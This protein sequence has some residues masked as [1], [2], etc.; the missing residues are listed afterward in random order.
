MTKSSPQ[1][2][3]E[4]IMKTR[5]ALI[6]AAVSVLSSC[7]TTA[8]Y[9][10]SGN[11]QRFQDGIYES[12]PGFMTRAEKTELQ[13]GTDVLIAKTKASEIYLF[14]DI[15]DTI[16]IPQNM[17]AT[18]RYDKENGSTAVTVADNPYDW[19]NNID[20]WSVYGSMDFSWRYSYGPWG[21]P[22][23]WERYYDPWY[24]TGWY[25]GYWGWYG[26]W[27]GYGWYDPWYSYGSWW[28]WHDPYCL[29]WH[30]HYCGWYGGW[31]HHYPG[32]AIVINDNRWHGNR[33]MT[34]SDRVFTSRVSTRG[35]TG[36]SGR[37]GRSTTVQSS[38][39]GSSMASS[40]RISPVQSRRVSSAAIGQ[41]SRQ[42][43]TGSQTIVPR[44][45][46]Q[47][48]RPA[49]QSSGPAA[50]FRRPAAQ[51]SG[52]GSYVSSGSSS[53][54]SRS[55]TGSGYSR[56]S[57]SSGPNYD[58]SSSSSYSRSS[59]S[60]SQSYSRSSSGSSVSRSSSS[61]GSSGGAGRSSGYS[62]GGGRR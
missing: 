33:S 19:R 39:T 15:K 62:G 59:S 8:K 40:A 56:S 47:Q 43:A 46:P 3:E 26:P 9:A 28:G 25:N 54:Y 13:T 17:S 53:G 51:S 16:V 23:Y 20:P 44:T 42:S 29:G 32:V 37:S 45:A 52:S 30:H 34:G 10:S 6:I 31:G 57:S 18:I 55:T 24:Y 38:R 21:H 4:K 41:P 48:A 50:N 58:R 49:A 2:E 61:G 22:G 12:S 5:H 11:G 60:S 14:G 1:N 27:N 35:G 7:G 36:N